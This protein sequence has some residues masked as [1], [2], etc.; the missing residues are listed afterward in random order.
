[1]FQ[2]GQ[3]SGHESFE[4]PK[5]HIDTEAINA[6]PSAGKDKLNNLLLKLDAT[7]IESK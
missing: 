7:S 1:M 5:Q 3:F 4:L 2:E 6:N